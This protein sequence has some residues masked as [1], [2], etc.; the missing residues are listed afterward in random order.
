MLNWKLQNAVSKTN[1]WHHSVFYIKSMVY[2]FFFNLLFADTLSSTGVLAITLHYSVNW[3]D[4]T[5]KIL[6]FKQS[7]YLKITCSHNDFSATCQCKACPPKSWF[8]L[9][10]QS[11]LI[12]I[13]FRLFPLISP[14]RPAIR[15]T[16]H[17]CIFSLIHVSF[18]PPKKPL[19]PSLP[20]CSSLLFTF[21]LSITVTFSQA[22]THFCSK[23]FPSLPSPLLHHI[24]PSLPPSLVRAQRM[25]AA[26]SVLS[27]S[28][29]FVHSHSGFASWNTEK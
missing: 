1:G 11:S 3:T 25:A 14:Y 12:V 16:S 19:V 2:A 20:S 26:H 10:D 5:G 18:L 9:S 21:S 22:F 29:R 8:L 28:R 27:G 15:L 4:T 24:P 17:L 6:W 7:L 13:V 23:A